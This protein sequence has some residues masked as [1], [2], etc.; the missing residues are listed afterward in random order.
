MVFGWF[1]IVLH[2]SI[3]PY[4][5]PVVWLSRTVVEWYWDWFAFVIAF[6]LAETCSDDPRPY[7]L[8]EKFHWWTRPVH[9]WNFSLRL[10]ALMGSR[11]TLAE[12]CSP[13]Q[14]PPLYLIRSP[15][16][17]PRIETPYYINARNLTGLVHTLIYIP[18]PLPTITIEH[19]HWEEDQL[20]IELK[21]RFIICLD[22]RGIG[23]WF[24]N[25]AVRQPELGFR[26]G[27]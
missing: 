19:R 7:C 21:A 20:F 6:S 2:S 18:S 16:A 27:L 13:S 10:R 23:I 12:T 24:A 9:Q 3:F 17:K 14:I 8:S 26:I 22:K 11:H 15:D 25:F 4:F 5:Y 1:Y